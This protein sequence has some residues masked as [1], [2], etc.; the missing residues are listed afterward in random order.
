M[1]PR[2]GGQVSAL[3]VSLACARLSLRQR[4]EIQAENGRESQLRATE[5]MPP[6]ADRRAS[7]FF[8]M[9]RALQPSIVII[10]LFI[11]SFEPGD[12]EVSAW[13]KNSPP[14]AHASVFPCLLHSLRPCVP[15][16]GYASLR[17]HVGAAGGRT[18]GPADIQ[19]RQRKTRQTGTERRRQTE[20]LTGRRASRQARLPRTSAAPIARL[21][22]GSDAI[23]SLNNIDDNNSHN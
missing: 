10:V 12:R 7:P 1:A 23:P 21:A 8:I 16:R 17:P 6:R 13:A 14:F 19:R 11:C 5:R 9:I 20:R 15:V 3:N 2:Q 4:R 22:A 18:D